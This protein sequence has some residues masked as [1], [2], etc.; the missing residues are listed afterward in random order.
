MKKD[1]LTGFLR[2]RRKKGESIRIGD[3][4]EIKIQAISFGDEGYVDI[5]IVAPSSVKI[6]RSELIAK[7]P[8]GFE[9]HIHVKPSPF[10]HKSD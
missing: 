9:T 4:I 1:D 8:N 7:K 3:N 10:T 6:L 5:G 2:L